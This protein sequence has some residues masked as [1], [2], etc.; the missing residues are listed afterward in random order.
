M[1]KT[2]E[3]YCIDYPNTQRAWEGVQWDKYSSS[4]LDGQQ[5]EGQDRLKKNYIIEETLHG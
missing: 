4:G 1:D 5:V 2:P 3:Q